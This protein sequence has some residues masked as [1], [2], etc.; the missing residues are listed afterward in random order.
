MP[1]YPNYG[2]PP[3]ALPPGAM[4]PPQYDVPAVPDYDVVTSATDVSTDQVAT[5]VRYLKK[6]GHKKFENF[7]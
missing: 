7:F 1:A 4:E 5:E 2:P 6:N 3:G